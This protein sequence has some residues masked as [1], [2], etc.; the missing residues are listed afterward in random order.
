MRIWDRI[1][2]IHKSCTKQ[3]KCLYSQHPYRE[4]G[5]SLQVHRGPSRLAHMSR[6]SKETLSQIRMEAEKWPRKQFP[7][8][9][10]LTAAQA[11]LHSYTLTNA[12]LNNN[13]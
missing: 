3:F 5:K 12:C 10:M 13:L 9:R 1:L 11:Y 6:N 8:L 2:S 4:M 7:N